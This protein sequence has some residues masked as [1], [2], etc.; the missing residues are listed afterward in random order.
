M[1]R[2]KSRRRFA[3]TGPLAGSLWV[4][5]PPKPPE[6]EREESS[7]LTEPEPT[8]EEMASAA[9]LPDDEQDPGWIKEIS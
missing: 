8:K 4:F 6:R 5:Q 9:D 3:T 2:P 7:G 1:H